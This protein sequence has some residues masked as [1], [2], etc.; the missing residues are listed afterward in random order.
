LFL[1]KSALSHLVILLELVLFGKMTGTLG[2][3]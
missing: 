3:G 2:G 1:G